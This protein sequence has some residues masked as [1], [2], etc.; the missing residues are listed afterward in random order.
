VLIFGL[1]V[2]LLPATGKD[3]RRGGQDPTVVDTVR[4]PKLIGGAAATA[5]CVLGGGVL[6]GRFGE[7]D[8]ATRKP[9]LDLVLQKLPVTL[10]AALPAF[11]LRW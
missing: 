6:H 1:Q 11:R 5:L 7:V 4:K 3:S 10:G 2:Q 9:V 8:P